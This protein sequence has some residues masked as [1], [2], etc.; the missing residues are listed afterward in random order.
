MP[1][2]KAGP[3]LGLLPEHRGPTRGRGPTV[4]P[5]T[6]FLARSAEAVAGGNLALLNPDSA[7]GLQQSVGNQ[8]LS[9][10]IAGEQRVQRVGDVITPA[11]DPGTSVH[12][13]LTKGAA[14]NNKQAV[15]EAQQKLASS[16]EGPTGLAAGGTFDDATET[17]VKAFQKKNGKPESGVVDKDTWTLLDAQ[18]KSSVGRIERAWSETLGGVK[19]AMTSKYSYNIDDTKILVSVGINFVA[20][21]AHPPADLTAVVNKWKGRILA[22]WN[23]F[24]AQKTGAADKR[25]IV[26]E[27]LPS[28]GNTVVVI[29]AM[30]GSDAGHWSVP[31]NEHDNGPSHEFGHMIGLAD[32]YNQTLSEY[33]RLHPGMSAEKVAEGKG[34]GGYGADSYTDVT[35]MMGLG[36]LKKHDDA[37]ADPE[38]RHLREFAS[39][40]EK[41]LGGT[42]EAVKK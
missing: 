37:A 42:W 31:D 3:E 6:S 2:H 4:N 40:V 30:V 14:D 27:I 33:Q 35:S 8:S 15:M 11:P 36:A 5:A 22:R 12:P 25:D 13:T 20:D 19:Y 18:G 9:Q 1:P 26:F 29:D 28:G 23:Q 10:A 16:P 39:F 21:S 24:K 34:K 41:Y 7:R 17:A 38:P 32:E